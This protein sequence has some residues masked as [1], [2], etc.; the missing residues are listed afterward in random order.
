MRYLYDEVAGKRYKTIEI[1]AEE[2]SWQGTPR[3]R[4]IH[5][6]DMVVVRIAWEDIETRAALK[7][8]GAISRPRQ[9]L[10][11][12]DWKTVRALRLQRKVVKEE[13]RRDDA[14]GTI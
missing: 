3:G 6:Y 1:I 2:I 9:H 5:D 4:R 11:E 7:A 8:A 12:V 13:N 14:V 10:W